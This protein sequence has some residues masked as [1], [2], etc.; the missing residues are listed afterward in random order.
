MFRHTPG[1]KGGSSSIWGFK[2]LHV[3]LKVMM[4][5][6]M[7]IGKPKVLGLED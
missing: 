7:L 2:T 5:I 6:V 3:S 4:L 1:F